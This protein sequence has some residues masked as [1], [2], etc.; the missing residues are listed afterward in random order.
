MKGRTLTPT[1]A[2]AVVFR[3]N[4]DQ[5]L[6]LVISSSN[7][8]HWVLPNGHIDP[9][10]SAET[11]ALRELAEEAGITGEMICMLGI[12]HYEKLGKEVIS[13]YFLVRAGETVA[14]DEQRVL[15]WEDERAAL[16]LL[17]FQ[18]TRSALRQGAEALRRRDQ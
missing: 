5:I 12:Q 16:D 4:G 11:A 6:F 3:K 10:E 15:R 13:Q 1:H 7:G 14:T 17:S 2:G 9:G 18:P 8:L